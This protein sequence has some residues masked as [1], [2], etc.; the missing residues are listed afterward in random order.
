MA[1]REHCYRIVPRFRSDFHTGVS[2]SD[3]V[4]RSLVRSHV[5]AF[6]PG[7]LVVVDGARDVW[8]DDD[9]QC[10]VLHEGETV[11]IVAAVKL[12]KYSDVHGENVFVIG[13]C[14]V[15]WT[16]VKSFDKKLM[17]LK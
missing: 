1:G 15:G 4:V 3:R 7:D 10:G 17:V 6:V 11:L 8:I 2:V 5:T 9:H 13:R 12:A 16:F 14:C